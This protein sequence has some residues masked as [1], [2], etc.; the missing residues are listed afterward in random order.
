[1]HSLQKIIYLVIS[2]V[3][4][5]GMLYAFSYSEASLCLQSGVEGDA[6]LRMKKTMLSEDEAASMLLRATTE[7]E[8]FSL[9]AELARYNTDS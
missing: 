2:I 7:P 3:L 1:M 6:Y 4:S 9:A 5:Q 8:F